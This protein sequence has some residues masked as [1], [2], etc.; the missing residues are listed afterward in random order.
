MDKI[1]IDANTLITRSIAANL[2]GIAVKKALGAH[3][4]SGQLSVIAIGK[5]AWTMAQAAHEELGNRIARGIVITKY[6]HSQGSIPG[7]EI[8]EAGHPLSDENTIKGTE[9]ALALAESLGAGD[10]LLFLISGGGSALFEK[11][12]PGLSLADIVT[13]NNQ[14]LASGADI[15][16]I[17][18]IRK[19]LSCVKGGRFAQAC[20][21]A[22]VFTVV[23]SDVLGDRLDS[24]ASGPA[25]PDRS[26]AEE[27]LAV[28]ARY[29]LKLSDTILEYLAKETPKQLDNVETVI[30]GSVRTLCA[31]A[32]EIAKELGY[33]PQILC[34]DM[35]GEA[36]E[37]G[38]LMAAIARQIAGGQYSPSR[39]CAII[40]GGETIVHLK[41]KGKGGRNQEIALA[42]AEGIAGIA[43]LTIFSVGS[44]GTDGPTDAAGGIVD[45]STA[46]KLKAKGLKPL[47]ILDNNDAYNGLKTVDSLVLTGPTGTNVNDLSIILAR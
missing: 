30:T 32:A 47:D 29:K 43:N 25:A 20:A 45:G 34:S 37:V 23:L 17:N 38:I 3:H 6:E 8:I 24:I 42:A 39:P 11:P 26:T 9:K 18:M 21:P 7:M 12:L 13:V 19:R 2:P 16:E 31:S 46:A 5:A 41:G 1:N 15:V 10:E 40:L 4:F 33:A 28:A 22:K 44:D 14:L 35:N 27:A 36:R